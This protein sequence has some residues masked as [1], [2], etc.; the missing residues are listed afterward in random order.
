MTSGPTSSF[1]MPLFRI[2]TA[3]LLAGF[4]PGVRADCWIDWKY[5]APYQ[6]SLHR[7]A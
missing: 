2:L 7:H 6:D 4:L 3:I 5:V 1:S